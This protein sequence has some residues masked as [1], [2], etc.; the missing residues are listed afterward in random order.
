[1]SAAKKIETSLKKEV[2]ELPK[3]ISAKYLLNF[4]EKIKSVETPTELVFNFEKTSIMEPMSYP[5]LHRIKNHILKTGGN[6]QSVHISTALY[7]R[8]QID[9]VAGLFNYKPQTDG[10][11]ASFK[12]M[13]ADF[14]NHFIEAAIST[15]NIQ[16]NI[17]VT[18]RPPELKKN[19]EL[20]VDIIGVIS[21]VSANLEGSVS[22]CFPKETFIKV[23]NLLFGETHTEISH[24][25]EDAAGELL[26]MIF[27]NAKGQLNNKFNCQI[28][29]AIPTIIY[30]QK[31]KLK[32]T[33]GPT[34]ILP[35][36]CEA[37]NFHLEIEAV[38]K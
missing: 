37:G 6:F 19:N 23:C 21:L 20:Q 30:G 33:K 17:K 36:E 5:H 8:L 29:K 26:N 38:E 25:I 4:F 16:A 11:S 28:Q 27:G 3:E 22:L 9:G 31:L 34:I 10:K 24:E 14:L 35:F 7:N 2:V 12:K 13:D 18:N 32:Q 15:F 1:M